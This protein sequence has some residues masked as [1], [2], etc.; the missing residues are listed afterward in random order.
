TRL[1]MGGG[2]QRIDADQ[3]GGSAGS[4]VT[5]PASEA[6]DEEVL[7]D[8]EFY[9]LAQALSEES[10]GAKAGP[11]RYRGEPVVASDAK[12]PNPTPVPQQS[13]GEGLADDDTPNPFAHEAPTGVQDALVDSNSSFVLEEIR[14]SEASE[15]EAATGALMEEAHR[16]YEK[17]KFESACDLLEAVLERDEEHAE[18]ATLLET[19]EGELEREYKTDIGPLTQSPELNVKMSAIPEM[20]LD[21]RFGY[22]LSQIDG[23]ST[24][25]DLLDLSSMS[26]LETLEVLSEMLER[27]LINLD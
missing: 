6:G 1:G 22:L 24:F 11:S 26:R 23:V 21:H 9:Q 3:Q 14:Q 17:G 27:D 15:I 25:E 2:G 8:D 19:V 4:E 5:S 12:T 16:L 10:S 13:D 18:A 7:D 20:N